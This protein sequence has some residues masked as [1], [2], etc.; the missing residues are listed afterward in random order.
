MLIRIPT[1]TRINSLHSISNGFFTHQH[2]RSPPKTLKMEAPRPNSKRPMCPSCSKPSRLCLCTRI[3]SPALENKYLFWLLEPVLDSDWGGAGCGCGVGETQKQKIEDVGGLSS[4]AEDMGLSQ[5]EGH[6]RVSKGESSS[7]DESKGGVVVE[8]ADELVIYGSELEGGNGLVTNIERWSGN[9]LFPKDKPTVSDEA[10]WVDKIDVQNAM[11]GIEEAVMSV[12]VGKHGVIKDLNSIW[13]LPTQRFTLEKFD[14][15][16]SS[17]MAIDDLGKGFIVKKMQ[18]RGMLGGN[19]GLELEE[20]NEFEV[21]VP[22]GSVLL[23]P[24]EKAVGFGELK[25]MNI[26]VNNL[27]V[28]DGTWA[29]ARRMY[30][31]NPW[32][33]LLP[34][35]RLDL[36]KHSLYSEVR[37]QPKAGYLSTIE[38]I[39]NALKAL[40]DNSEGL[41]NLL[42]VFGSMVAD[43]RRC[44]DERL[45]KLSSV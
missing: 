41:D 31:E 24:S 15:I 4:D 43:Q 16:L 30:E 14:K 18:K 22:P 37:Q 38:S 2:W 28:L 35:L 39:V 8:N 23:F 44:K 10:V 1:P 40:G 34:H 9:Y 33:R 42:D 17:Q 6:S 36:E 45:H 12:T 20:C 25:D 29:K 32:L 26:E 11:Q 27:I 7:L 19:V 21:V 13:S 5:F 3:R